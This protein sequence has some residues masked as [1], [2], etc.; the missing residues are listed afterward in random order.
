MGDIPS[1]VNRWRGQIGLPVAAPVDIAKTTEE[2]DI[3]GKKGVFVDIGGADVGK[4]MLALILATGE[5]TWFF[6]LTGDA[7]RVGEQRDAFLALVKSLQL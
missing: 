5:K 6:K 7:A 4:R 1:N 2:M 3:S